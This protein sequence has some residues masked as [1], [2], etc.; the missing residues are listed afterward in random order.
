MA[1]EPTLGSREPLRLHAFA[2]CAG[3]IYAA[4]ITG[5]G[6]PPRLRDEYRHVREEND[7][8]SGREHQSSP[9]C[10]AH[11]CGRSRR[12]A[13]P[14]R[15]RCPNSHR[16]LSGGPPDRRPLWFNA[17]FALLGR[18]FD[19]PDFLRRPTEEILE[20]FREGGT[21][22]HLRRDVLGR[23][24]WSAPVLDAGYAGRVSVTPRGTAPVDARYFNSQMV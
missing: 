18:R 6:T 21:L 16:D 19:Y 4:D 20:R 3:Y 2:L 10:R 24:R 14:P 8:T 12:R 22:I 11:C 7:F 1:S 23:R 9:S 15:R 5:S 17:T 13:V